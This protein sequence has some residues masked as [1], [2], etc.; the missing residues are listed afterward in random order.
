[1]AVTNKV[2]TLRDGAIVIKDGDSPVNTCT[3][4]CDVGDLRWTETD[5]RVTVMCRGTID[6]H[7]PGDEVPVELSTTFKWLQLL[8]YTNDSSDGITP[9][10]IIN[11]LDSAFTSVD[12]GGYA[13]IWE[14]TVTDPAGVASEKITFANVAKNTLECSEGDEFNAIAFTG[15]DYEVIPT[16]ARV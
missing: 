11:N 7:R 3:V 6:H 2:R 9:Y 1:M 14:F 13:L 15:T 12:T 8:G 10:E 4:A 16:V 5:Q